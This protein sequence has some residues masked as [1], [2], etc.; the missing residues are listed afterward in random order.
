M[1]R[2]KLGDKRLLL[3]GCELHVTVADLI[4]LSLWVESK[5]KL[6]PFEG[7]RVSEFAADK[8]LSHSQQRIKW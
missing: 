6:N 3:T 2:D 8:P 4:S 5:N 7:L 1:G